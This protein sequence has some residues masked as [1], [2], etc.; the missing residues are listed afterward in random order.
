MSLITEAAT[1]GAAEVEATSQGMLIESTTRL[2]A[3]QANPRARMPARPEYKMMEWAGGIIVI[4]G[5]LTIGLSL[6]GGLLAVVLGV[7][8]PFASERNSGESWVMTLAGLMYGLA[9][10]ISGIM[11]LGLGQALLALR[12]MAINSWHVRFNTTPPA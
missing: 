7:V 3:E 9:G 8:L 1:V 10:A 4:V 5:W 12:D 6:A 11:I 2:D